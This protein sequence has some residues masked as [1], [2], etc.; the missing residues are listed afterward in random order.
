ML[1]PTK[2]LVLDIQQSMRSMRYQP[3]KTAIIIDHVANYTRFG[4]PDDDREWSLDDR[5]KQV[6]SNQ[7]SE[8]GTT[9]CTNCFAILPAGTRICPYCDYEIE[10]E[11][12]DKQIDETAKIELI[13]QFKITANYEDVKYSKMKPSEAK[14]PEEMYKIAKAKGYKPGWAYHQIIARGWLNKKVK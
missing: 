14:S 11:T 4:L 12:Q 8:V 7:K 3:S 5:K 9:M 1:R 13:N 10:I 6:N 2:S